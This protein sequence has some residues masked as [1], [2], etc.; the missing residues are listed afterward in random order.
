MECCDSHLGHL[1]NPPP[2]LSAALSPLPL[3]LGD[4]HPLLWSASR[5]HSFV[6]WPSNQAEAPVALRRW[7]PRQD[8]LD[9]HSHMS[10]LVHMARAGEE[11]PRE[12][13][14]QVGSGCLH[15]PVYKKNVGIRGDWP[16]PLLEQLPPS[17]A[18]SRLEHPLQIN[19][20]HRRA[21]VSTNIQAHRTPD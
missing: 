9:R 17:L 4:D 1:I 18:S 6:D 14:A 20:N 16:P 13:T 7:L 2:P 11:G 3:A 19:Q 12:Q 5:D 15:H 10:P 8:D 21:L